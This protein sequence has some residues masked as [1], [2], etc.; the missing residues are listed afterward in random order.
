M[1]L[2][3]PRHVL[4]LSGHDQQEISHLRLALARL[5]TWPN[6][7][8]PNTL[9]ALRRRDPS[10][11]SIAPV[12]SSP[13]R[14]ATIAQGLTVAH[15]LE[16]D[17][18]G[19]LPLTTKLKPALPPDHAQTRP[20][21][22]SRFTRAHSDRDV[23]SCISCRPNG[24]THIYTRR[25]HPICPEAPLQPMSA[26]FSRLSSIH[27]MWSEVR[28]HSPYRPKHTPSLQRLLRWWKGRASAG[29]IVNESKHKPT[30]SIA[31]G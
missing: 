17:G 29:G 12:K 15:L 6:R 25:F 26:T 21:L 8:R 5:R 22:H 23:V 30:L 24:H 10:G 27:P 4:G 13:I 2:A 3:G 18:S 19:D 9:I 28:C 31:L 20:P 1:P 14:R 11:N 7:A 16:S